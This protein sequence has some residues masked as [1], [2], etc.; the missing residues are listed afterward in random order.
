MGR[1]AL[2]LILLAVAA[3]STALEPTAP[4]LSCVPKDSCGC[5]IL[6][7]SNIC[8]GGTS[9]IF[10]DLAD[11]SP[12]QF[13]LGRGPVTATSTRPVSNTFSPAAGDSWTETYRH[14]DGKIEIHYTPRASTCS[15][16]AQGEQCEYFDVLARVLISGPHGSYRYSGVGTCGC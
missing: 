11:G 6:L 3:C 13:N 12:L 4:P 15:K 16:L 8:P 1:P 5:A 7:D 2:L 9:S 14:S 10:H